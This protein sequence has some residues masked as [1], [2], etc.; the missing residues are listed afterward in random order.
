[1]TDSTSNSADDGILLELSNAILYMPETNSLQ[2][3]KALSVL[4]EEVEKRTALTLQRVQT[5]PNDTL[6]IMVGSIR[7]LKPDVEKFTEIQA[8]VKTLQPEGYLIRNIRQD[9]QDILVILGADARGMLYGVGKFLRK[10]QL[11]DSSIKIDSALFI[12]SSPRSLVRGHQLG[13]RPKTNAYDAWIPAQFEQYI[14]ELAI[15][16]ANSIEL[17]PPRTDDDETGPHFKVPP[18]DMMIQLSEMIHS[19]GLDTWVWYPNLAADYRDPQTQSDELAERDEIFRRV[20]HIH[21]LFM[22]GGDPGDLDADLLFEWAGQVA[23]VLHKYHPNAKIWLSPQV[24]R[25]DVIDDWLKTFFEKVNQEPAWLGGIVFGPWEKTPLP[26]L[27]SKINP[28]YPIRR[29]EDICHNFRCQYPIHDWDLAFALTYGRESINPRPVAFKHIHNLLTDYSIGTITYSEGIY[30]DVNKFVWSDQDWNPDTPVIET[31]RDYAR[32]FIDCDL[33]EEIAQGMMSLERNWKGSLLLNE[34]VDV[35]LNQWR[36]LEAAVQPHTLRNYRFQ[37][38]LLRAYYDAYQ[39]RRLFYE[40]ELERAALD[41]LQEASVIGSLASLTKMEAI[42]NQSV[43]KPVAR[44]LRE[45]C[46]ELADELFVRIGA[47]TT[48]ERHQAIS[49]DRG[50]FVTTIDTPLNNAKFLYGRAASIRNIGSEQKRL[51]AISEVIHRTAPGPGGFYDNFGLPN[52]L[53]RVDFEVKWEHDPGH[54]ASP[55]LMYLDFLTRSDWESSTPHDGIPLSWIQSISAVY[56]VPLKILYCDLDPAGR[57]VIRVVYT[58]KRNA[59]YKVKMVANQ[60]FVLHE[61]VTVCNVTVVDSEIPAAA[62]AD[63]K[64]ELTCFNQ[65]GD[66][67]REIAEIL[68]RKL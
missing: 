27:R 39:R 31:I 44:A 53:E 63:G 61:N 14:R 29:Y 6:V 30:D 56:D 10:A 12:K 37:M 38:G 57:Y 34:V 43:L 24:M 17:L 52:S 25:N 40:T 50:A 68:I 55:R 41:A 42:L 65:G 4:T 46:D 59:P 18:L 9:G 60:R 26:D 35:T 48:V 64:L 11:R 36:E 23:E 62:L 54:L 3:E 16:G 47:Q 19:Y 51:T 20:P 2:E 1:M 66:R 32:F 28:K 15:F 21:A 8:D 45:R 22:P 33:T 58:G 7:R 49:W 13:Y 67:G 5:W